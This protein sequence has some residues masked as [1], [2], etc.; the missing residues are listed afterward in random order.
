M[1]KEAVLMSLLDYDDREK[2]YKE[3]HEAQKTPEGLEIFLKKYT[4]DDVKRLGVLCPHLHKPLKKVM[5]KEENSFVGQENNVFIEKHCR[6]TPVFTHSH[7]YFEMFYVL[8]GSCLNTLHDRTTVLPKNSFVIIAPYVEHQMGVFDDSVVL[9]L[10]IKRSTFDNWVFSVLRR[11]NVLADFFM[12]SMTAKS[13]MTSLQVALHNDDLA[14][15][16]LQMVDEQAQWDD[17]TDSILTGIMGIFFS[18]L[19]RCCES[20]KDTYTTTGGTNEK[21]ISILRYVTDNYRTATLDDTAS[22]MGY[23]P[24]HCSRLIKELCGESFVKLLRRIRMRKASELLMETGLS[25]EKISDYIGYENPSAFNKVFRETYG[26]TP[27]R[28]RKQ[29]GNYGLHVENRLK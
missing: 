21:L 2:F 22:H 16:L 25:I 8:T 27:S 14:D 10:R 4:R 17:H 28:Y 20:G 3:Y 18:K 24:E 13:T 19:S 7:D 26:L 1:D 5:L 12:D 11:R 23:S 29:H 6:Y 9:N 15:I